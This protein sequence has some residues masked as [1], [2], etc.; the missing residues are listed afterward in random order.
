MDVG[1]HR[2]EDTRYYLEKGF[3]VIA[4]EARAD[5]VQENRAQ[6]AEQ[7][8]RGSL[9]IVHSAISD[10]EGTIPFHVFPGASVWGTA[11]PR[12][13]QRNE[14]MGFASNE[15]FVPA[16]RFESILGRYGI[17]YYLKVD[18]EGLDLLCL[19]ALHEFRQRPAYVSVELTMTNFDAAFESVASLFNLGYRKFKL[20]NQ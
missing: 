2:G 5:F 18:I 11:D 17:P 3:R 8:E 7:I 19:Q 6:F 15:I 20:V 1:M 14:A 12:Y 4:I 13:R 9:E 10:T 16:T